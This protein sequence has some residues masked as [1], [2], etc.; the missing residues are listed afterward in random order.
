MP[1]GSHVILFVIFWDLSGLLMGRPGEEYT[2]NKNA[3]F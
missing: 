3:I 2:G 1:Q